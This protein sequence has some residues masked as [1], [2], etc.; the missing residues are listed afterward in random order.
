MTMSFGRR[1]RMIHLNFT[2]CS[3]CSGSIWPWFNR[4]RATFIS[5][6]TTLCLKKV[7]KSSTK[8]CE[9][10]VA[11]FCFFSGLEF[12]VPEPNSIRPLGFVLAKPVVWN[13]WN[14]VVSC[15]VFLFHF[16]RSWINHWAKGICLWEHCWRF[17]NYIAYWRT[18]IKISTWTK[19]QILLRPDFIQPTMH[20]R[21]AQR[22][23][24]PMPLVL[25]EKYVL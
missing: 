19:C 5:V 22:S 23:Q 7:L 17:K 16:R 1:H 8:R 2:C 4:W 15:R 10:S 20:V 9:V 24:F 18:F 25:V 14:L 3:T 6:S 11:L 13:Y 12:Y 21:L